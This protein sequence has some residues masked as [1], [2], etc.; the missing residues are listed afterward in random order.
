[1][2]VSN[3]YIY[4]ALNPSAD[5]AVLTSP[6]PNNNAPPSLS[7]SS[8][9]FTWSAGSSETAYYLDVGTTTQANYYYSSGSLPTSTLSETVSGLPTNGSTVVVTLYT[10]LGGTWYANT[11]DFHALNPSAG[12]A[13]LTSPAPNNNTP[14]SLSGSSVTFT[15]SAG[16]GE[17]AYYLD[18]GTTTQANYYYSSGSLPTSTLSETVSGLPTNGSTVVVTLYT[19]L[20]GTWYANTYNFHAFNPSADQA[21]LTSPT[22]NNTSPPLLSGSS[23]TFTWSAGTGET[24]YYLDVGTTTQANYYYS[25][26]SLP[27][28]TL[29]ET[30]NSLPTDGSEV[31][32]T[33]YTMLG[34]TWYSNVYNF[35]AQ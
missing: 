34:G 20:G 35:T 14:P 31:V 30:V 24:A 23:V 26:G 8:V 16:T 21:V 7:G 25:S 2:W 17:T 32:V 5:Q 1:V 27:T 4:T 33:L 6:A 13:V 9:T 12:Q 19:Q 29:S 22:P 10:L 15:W 3:Q 11:Y 18:V 28:T